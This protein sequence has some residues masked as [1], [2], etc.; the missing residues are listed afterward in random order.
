MS[1]YSSECCS[2]QAS[3][4]CRN[5]T[6]L[7]NSSRTDWTRADTGFQSAMAFSTVG[8]LLVGTNVLATN[9]SGKITMKLALLTTSGVRTINP[10]V[11]ITQLNAYANS[12]RRRNPRSASGTEEWIRQ[13]TTRPVMTMTT[14]EM[15]LRPTSAVVRPTST[16]ERLIGRDRNRSMSPFWMSSAILDPVMVEPKITVWARMPGSRKSTYAMPGIG[17]ALPK[18]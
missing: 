7:P 8:K 10:T 18:T 5:G 14:I 12:S 16:A 4:V 11:A 13:P 2:D 15:Q 1:V 3:E 9:V 17:T 6:V